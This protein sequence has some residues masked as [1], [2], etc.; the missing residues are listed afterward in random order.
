MNLETNFSTGVSYCNK[1]QNNYLIFALFSGNTRS[2]KLHY[3]KPKSA[4]FLVLMRLISINT[5]FRMSKVSCPETSHNHVFEA[6][7][8]GHQCDEKVK[9]SVR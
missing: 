4:Y 9:Y 3:E 8:Q 6:L 7:V 5:V 1:T 2:I